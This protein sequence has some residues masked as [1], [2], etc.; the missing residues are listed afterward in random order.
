M[1]RAVLLLSSGLDS[2]ANLVLST[3][4]DSDQQFHVEL[5]L[6]IDYG[7]RSSKAELEH[8]RAL[9]KHYGVEHVV[10][11]FSHFPKFIGNHSALLGGQDVPNLS[12]SVLDDEATTTKSAKAVW[13]PNRNGVFLSLAAALAE[14]R[15]LDAV[16]VGFNAE[17]AVTFPDNTADYMQAMTHSFAYSTA[18]R[19]EVVSATH[20]MTKKQIVQSLSEKDFPFELVW[21]C[22]HNEAT[23]CGRCESCQRL[24]RALETGLP[25]EQSREALAKVFK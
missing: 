20:S 16:A 6:T 19:V 22:Y 5:A 13:V 15:G 7:Q 21:S 14:S 3:P 4:S 1:K 8:A 18:N 10:L 2:A 11:D 24:R 12:A 9:C 17:E 25:E 23:H